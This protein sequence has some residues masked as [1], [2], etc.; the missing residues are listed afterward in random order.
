MEDEGIRVRVGRWT[1]AAW[2][3]L[4][5]A[6][7]L[8]LGLLGLGRDVDVHS[9]VTFRALTDAVLP[10]TPALGSELGAVHVPGGLAV[11]LD[12]FLV[13]YV[14]DEFQFG[15]PH[16]GPHGNLPLVDPIAHALD[17]AALTLLARGENERE[18]SD[19]RPAALLAPGEAS[20]RE[21][22]N[23]AGMFSKLSRRD[24]L[25]AIHVLD[26]FELRISPAGGDLFEFDA[27]LVGQLV[28][29]FTE[30]IY[31]SEWQG[32]EEF[33]LPPSERVHPNDPSAVQGWRQTGFPGFA[34]G[35]AA[36][37]G[38]LGSDDGPLGAGD[39]WATIDADAAAS[40]HIARGPGAF[41]DD[42]YDTSGYEEPFP[43]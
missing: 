11:G 22:E 10:E 28:V 5:S 13:T 35:Y 4:T 21:V 31:Y 43:E 20:P 27:G 8:V 1:D 40:V 24:R 12:D 3:A 33:T 41:R 19:D 39:V 17:F 14:D 15:L 7:G 18:P 6:A 29:G 9:R 32:Y 25:R 30:L 42:D 34:D 26:E 38:Y 37:R 16:V 23:E 36:L 2:R